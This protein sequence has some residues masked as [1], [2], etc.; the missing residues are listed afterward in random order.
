MKTVYLVY[1]TPDYD[2][3]NCD[4]RT[5]RSI[6]LELERIPYRLEAC[7]E[8]LGDLVSDQFAEVEYLEVWR[9]GSRIDVVYPTPEGIV[10]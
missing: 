5:E 2:S 7:A 9:N 6:K 8:L 4:R 1:S 10:T 3:H